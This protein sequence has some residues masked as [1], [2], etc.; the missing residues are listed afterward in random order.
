MKAIVTTAYGNVDVLAY[1]DVE[2]ATVKENEI[3]VR[4]RAVG[5]NPIDWKVR[6]GEFKILTGLN[7]PRILGNDFAGTVE[8][9]GK[10]IVGYKKGDAVWGFVES[11]D[12]GTYAEYV[13]VKEHEVGRM[14]DNLSFE[15]AASFPTVGLTAYQ[16]L[17]RLAE[18]KK[19]YH[20]LINGCSGGVGL[21]ALQIAKTYDCEVTGV[22]STKNLEL[23]KKMGTDHVIDYTNQD[24]VAVQEAYDLFFDVVANQTFLQA[25][26]TL[27]PGGMYIPTLPS[28]QSMVLGPLN[29]LFSSKKVK[30]FDCKA[31]TEDLNDLKAMVEAG[32]LKP[33][34]E[35][36]YPWH[37][38]RLAH[39]RSER[40]HVV[41]KL[42]LTI[43]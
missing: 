7:P 14:P 32:A 8:E 20:I 37:Q 6:N 4:V 10:E 15:E 40:G 17:L 23:I 39:A 21:A 12:R 3:R 27:R 9:L 24:V 28:L 30:V 33:I 2:K 41:G 19:G 34:I 31:S 18:I 13:N 22:A 43:A 42:V 1:Q 11:F 38:V 36:I 29:N 16:T 35:K 26:H 25:R 5:I